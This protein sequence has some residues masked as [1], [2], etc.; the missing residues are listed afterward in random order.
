MQ[1]SMKISAGKENAGV[2]TEA[3]HYKALVNTFGIDNVSN[4]KGSS[5]GSD[6]TVKLSNTIITFESKTSNTDIFD[7]GVIGVDKNGMIF[8]ASCF[9]SNSQFS[10]VENL[11]QNNM[12]QLIEY[13]SSANVFSIPHVIDKDLFNDIKKNGSLIHMVEKAPLTN[14]IEQSFCYSH[15]TIKK[16]NYLLIDN[17]VFLVS[18][19]PGLDPLG[20]AGFGAALLTDNDISMYSLRTARSGSKNGKA[21]V[22]LRLQYRLNKNLPVSKV[23][24]T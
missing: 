23:R 18:A 17:S 20:L 11:I 7:A 6:F 15:N 3:N 16:A 22:T 12:D 4:P 2:Q 19:K 24:I 10:L 21:S 8:N 9:L 14:I 5:G 1:K 13:T